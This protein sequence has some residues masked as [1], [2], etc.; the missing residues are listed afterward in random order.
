[1]ISLTPV[2]DFIRRYIFKDFGGFEV[3]I[4]DSIKNWGYPGI[5]KK[6]IDFAT[7]VS[8]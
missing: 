4:E 6:N 5:K 2:Y 3:E 7:Q 1:M 8:L